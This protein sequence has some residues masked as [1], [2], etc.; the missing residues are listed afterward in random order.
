M[1]MTKYSGRNARMSPGVQEAVSGKGR[2]VRCVGG[3]RVRAGRHPRLAVELGK[4]EIT[5]AKRL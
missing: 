4:D 1:H 5:S 3:R 2:L